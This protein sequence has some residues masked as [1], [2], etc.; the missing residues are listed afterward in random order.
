MVKCLFSASIRNGRGIFIGVIKIIPIAIVSYNYRKN[1][2]L[3][4]PNLTN[5]TVFIWKEQEHIYKEK[6]P[7]RN[8]VIL[9]PTR[10]RCIQEKRFKV[11]QYFE[12]KKIYK[13]WMFDDDFKEFVT[14]ESDWKKCID[15]FS[16]LEKWEYL[17]DEHPIVCFD[18][19]NF[20]KLNNTKIV[21]PTRMF[22]GFFGMNT[23]LC[24]SRFRN[25]DLFEDVDLCYRIWD[26][27]KTI[28]KI[29]TY[30]RTHYP[31]N[32][33]KTTMDYA[34]LSYN[35]F[36]LYGDRCKIKRDASGRMRIS[37]GKKSTVKEGYYYSRLK[38]TL[39]KD[40][41]S[42]LEK[43]YLDKRK[44]LRYNNTCQ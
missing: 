4:N 21:K 36:M 26:E 5:E 18:V 22:S 43:A 1:N 37:G 3:N 2:I 9:E 7:N 14:F 27:G 15:D 35:T 13:Y 24:K 12:E 32:G 38:N 6:W 41:F 30:T 29:P 25:L 42:E 10:K 39:F 17:L 11:Q 34:P 8:Y 31:C 44:Q 33:T 28:V 19:A 20:S 40:F 16:Y 23:Q